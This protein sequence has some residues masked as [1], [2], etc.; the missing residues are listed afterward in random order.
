MSIT[1]ERAA[2]LRRLDV[3]RRQL[4]RMSQTAFAALVDDIER[5]GL[6]ELYSRDAQRDAR[7]LI[8]NAETPY[9][10]VIV[11]MDLIGPHGSKQLPFV[12][13]SAFLHVAY[14]NAAGFRSLIRDRHAACP[15]S[16]IKPWRLILYSD[17]VTPSVALPYV[18]RRKFW[19]FYSAFV[20]L[21]PLTLSDSKSWITLATAQSE[22]VHND[23]AAGVSQIFRRMIRSYFLES[24]DLKTTGLWLDAG[25][26]DP[27]IRLFIDVGAFVQD[28]AAQAFTFCTKSDS[29]TKSCIK[30][31]NFYA[32]RSGLANEDGVDVL[33]CDLVDERDLVFAT[34]DDVY[35]A[36]GRIEAAFLAHGRTQPFFI[37]EQ[38]SGLRHEPE[39]LLADR[40]IRHLVRPIQHR[41]AR[42]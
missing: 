11:D 24:V 3:R 42:T 4:P 9:G 34:D 10:K 21:G 8:A 16:P 12:N 27:G 35:A 6:P 36:I 14:C 33:A 25:G 31:A 22:F 28:G 15:S 18:D 26:D 37:Q 13:L 29:A 39:G 2:K 32:R 5:H 1:A 38:A 30:C 17:E 23:V 19:A 41:H 7:T 40:S 20:E